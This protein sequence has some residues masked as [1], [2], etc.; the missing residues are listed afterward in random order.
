METFRGRYEREYGREVGKLSPEQ[1]ATLAEHDWPGN[2][3]ELENLVR[4]M[5]VLQD[6]DG[7]LRELGSGGT[8]VVDTAALLG[9]DDA[10]P[11]LKDVSKLAAME[12]EGVLIRRALERTGWNRREAADLLQISYKALLYKIRD[13]GI[14]AA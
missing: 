5:V 11:P 1:L 8:Q 4:R 14:Q 13:C 12:A 7:P 9:S 3:R 10:I 6:I 2:V